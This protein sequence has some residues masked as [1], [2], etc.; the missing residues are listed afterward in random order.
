MPKLLQSG[1][2]ISKKFLPFVRVI[3]YI[4]LNIDAI[5]IYPMDIL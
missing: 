3:L 2:K 1:P 5:Q 4:L